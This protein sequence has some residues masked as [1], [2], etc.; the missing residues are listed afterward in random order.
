MWE[1]EDNMQAQI[2]MVVDGEE[3]VY[4]TYSYN[5]NEEKNRVNELDMK[6]REEREVDTYVKEVEDGNN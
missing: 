3:Y 1:R 2:I 5:T 6:I 4:G